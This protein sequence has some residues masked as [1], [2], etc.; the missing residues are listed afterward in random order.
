MI[1]EPNWLITALVGALF[2]IAIPIWYKTTLMLYRRMNQGTLKGTWYEYNVSRIN[3]VPCIV[4]E[5]WEVRPNLKDALGFTAISAPGAQYNYKYKGRLR[6]ERNH[7]I[8]HYDAETHDEEVMCR[9]ELPAVAGAGILIG[10]WVGFDFDAEL[11]AGPQVLSRHELTEAELNKALRTVTETL[12][13][14]AVLAVKRHTP[15]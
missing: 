1:K 14:S 15:F 9:L 12:S 2:G 11:I 3:G 6:Q 13:T 10:L 8:A 7:V 4:R 5:I